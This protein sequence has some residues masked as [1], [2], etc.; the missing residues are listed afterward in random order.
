MSNGLSYIKEKNLKVHNRFL[1]WVCSFKG[2]SLRAGT[3]NDTGDVTNLSCV[4][5]R[6][7]SKDNLI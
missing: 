6:Y 4:L 7:V 5:E 1:V 2:S 3:K